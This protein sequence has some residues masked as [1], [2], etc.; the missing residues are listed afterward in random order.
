MT[1]LAFFF[2]GGGG[3]S[4]QQGIVVVIF[5]EWHIPCWDQIFQCC[6]AFSLVYTFLVS[7]PSLSGNLLFWICFLFLL[8][9]L[10]SGYY[11]RHWPSFHH[12]ASSPVSR[13]HA[14]GCWGERAAVWDRSSVLGCVEG[15]RADGKRGRRGPLPGWCRQ[16]AVE[17]GGTKGRRTFYASSTTFFFCFLPIDLFKVAVFLAVPA[18]DPEIVGVAHNS[19]T[20]FSGRS[21]GGFVCVQQFHVIKKVSR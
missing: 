3:R 11:S 21:V 19:N 6:L 7:C 1:L 20:A 13:R 10:L 5:F 18:I 17:G 2:W 16:G 14:G 12:V 9:Y 15:R 8:V 4:Y